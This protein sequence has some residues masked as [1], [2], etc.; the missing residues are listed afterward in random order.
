MALGVRVILAK[1]YDRQHLFQ[2]LNHGIIPL[3][4]LDDRGYDLVHRDDFW[5]CPGLTP[6]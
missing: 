4:F 2:L 1:S 5:S 3:T 6:S